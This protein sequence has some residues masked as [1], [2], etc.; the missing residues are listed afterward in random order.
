M[1]KKSLKNILLVCSVLV[2]FILLFQIWFSSYFLPNGYDYVMSG[3]NRYVVSPIR[4][5]FQWGENEDFSQN[6]RDMFRPEK[7]VL[8]VSGERRVFREEES[9]FEAAR[10]YADSL[11]SD[12]LSGKV[13]LKNRET[14]TMEEYTAV[15][16]G[17]SIYVDYGKSCDYRLFSF[18][19]CGE[20]QKRYADDLKSVSS[21]ILSMHD[22]IMNDVSVFIYDKQNG[23]IYRY[24]VEMDKASIDANLAELLLISPSELTPSY[25]F[26]LNFHKSQEQAPAKVLFEPTILMDVSTNSL[27][28]VRPSSVDITETFSTDLLRMFSI[29]T[30]A[31]WRYTDLSGA[32]VFV[33]NDATLT[34]YPD[35][36]LSYQVE[37]SGRGLSLS[38]VKGTYDI[39]AAA[40]DAVDFVTELCGYM[41]A[42]FYEHLQ[43][44]SDLLENAA[45]QGTY[46]IIFDYCMNGVPVRYQQE[47]GYAHA[48]KMELE[49]GHLKSYQ[50]YITTYENERNGE[51]KALLP[52]LNA[53]D[54]LVDVL[55]REPEPLQIWQIAPCYIAAGQGDLVPKWSVFVDESEQIVG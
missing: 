18:A 43:I 25:S 55:Y 17:K 5:L 36:F 10:N 51:E 2:A 48:I 30:R 12:F 29:N 24:V 42:D 35:G 27:P 47:N 50:Q 19:T 8:N 4:S 26:E 34:L 45:N 54:M 37:P 38:T 20:A 31:M 21:Y 1:L 11:L 13:T 52:L 22:G 3:V 9:G 28:S 7:I 23:N 15:L 6:F 53:A 33:E 39:Y 32:R 41:P 14:V 49:N 44:R 46:T 40:A 16:R